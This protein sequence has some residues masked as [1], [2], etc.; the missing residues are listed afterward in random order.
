[1]KKET[2]VSLQTFIP[3]YLSTGYQPRKTGILKKKDFLIEIVGNGR[4]A[5]SRVVIGRIR[6]LGLIL[7]NGETE[8]HQQRLHSQKRCYARDL[9]HTHLPRVPAFI[10]LGA[11]GPQYLRYETAHYNSRRHVMFI[12]QNYISNG[13]G[14][15]LH[16]CLEHTYFPNVPFEILHFPRG[17]TKNPF[18]I[19]TNVF[20]KE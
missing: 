17:R 15:K 4:V 18:C 14:L 3:V 1:L 11:Y 20:L 13:G 12:L 7:C 2:V 10:I 19:D 16:S 5:S 8:T 9:S 6:D